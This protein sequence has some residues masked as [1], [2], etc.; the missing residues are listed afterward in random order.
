[1]TLSVTPIY[2]ILLTLLFLALSYRVIVERRGNKFAYGNNE[3]HRIEA[4]IRAHANWAEY[5]PIAL[6]LMLM[7]ELQGIGANWLHLTGVILLIGRVLHG[8]GMSVKPR[9]FRFRVYGMILTITAIPLAL[10]LN[11]VALL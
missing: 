5:T 4:K 11:I 8:Y 1:M 3:S 6:L 2:A 9:D 10:L 7:A